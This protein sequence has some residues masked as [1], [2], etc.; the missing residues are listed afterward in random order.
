[1]RCRILP[2]RAPISSATSVLAA[3]TSGRRSGDIRYSGPETLRTAEQRPDGSKTGTATPLKPGSSSPIVKAAPSS[4][5][6]SSSERSSVTLV[7]VCSV[8][9]SRGSSKWRVSTGSSMNASRTLPLAVVWGSVFH[10]TQS[11]SPTRRGPSAWAMFTVLPSSRRARL[12]VS[13]VSSA[14]FSIGTLATSTRFWLLA[15]ANMPRRTNSGPSRKASLSGAR[16]RK[17]RLARV[18]ARRETMLLSVPSMLAISPTLYSLSI[19]S[20]SSSSL[21]ARSTVFSTQALQNRTRSTQPVDTTTPCLSYSSG[22]QRPH[23]CRSPWPRSPIK[24]DACI[25]WRCV[26][27]GHT[28]SS[29]FV[30]RIVHRSPAEG[31]STSILRGLPGDHPQYAADEKTNPWLFQEARFDEVPR[32][33][34]SDQPR[35]GSAA[36]YRERIR[37]AEEAQQDPTPYRQLRRILHGRQPDTRAGHLGPTFRQPRTPIGT[38]PCEAPAHLRILVRP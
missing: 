29:K 12:T 11:P 25:N 13:P 21:S 19:S 30:C 9:A 16:S 24:L 33:Y 23:C 28:S 22:R 20:K 8:T 14:K 3:A 17:P 5:T 34:L 35:C 4:L 10:P 27:S 15:A 37:G 7:I 31:R 2:R 38:G 18:A 6:R 36:G 32:I 26:S 1:M